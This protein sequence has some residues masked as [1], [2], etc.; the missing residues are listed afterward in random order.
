MEVVN[1]WANFTG[2]KVDDLGNYMTL[3]FY[4]DAKLPAQIEG[5]FFENT[6]GGMAA[7]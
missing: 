2:L 7:A 5:A 1:G 4:G 6:R 3:N